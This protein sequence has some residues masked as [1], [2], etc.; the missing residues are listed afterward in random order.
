MNVGSF[1]VTSSG[2]FALVER[3]LAD[4][5]REFQKNDVKLIALIL[6]MMIEAIMTAN[7]KLT[8]W[9]FSIKL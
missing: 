1:I 5:F 3:G 4:C 7:S 6:L 9:P 2:Y 8:D